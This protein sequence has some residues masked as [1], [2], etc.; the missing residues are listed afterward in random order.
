M[1]SNA[2]F[3]LDQMLQRAAAS[4][5][6]SLESAVDVEQS[7]AELHRQAAEQQTDAAEPGQ[8]STR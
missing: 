2:D 8:A 5:L 6:T 3:T 1:E 4:T 7:L